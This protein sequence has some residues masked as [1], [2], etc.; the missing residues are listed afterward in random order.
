[1]D[2]TDTRS[3]GRLDAVGWGLRLLIAASLVVDAVVRV[4]QGSASSLR[5]RHEARAPL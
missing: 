3:P 5:V 1:M 4:W 2:N